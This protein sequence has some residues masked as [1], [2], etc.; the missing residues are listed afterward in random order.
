[1]PDPHNGYRHKNTSD[2]V[3]GVGVRPPKPV[4]TNIL[5]RPLKGPPMVPI[6]DADP[7]CTCADMDGFAD[8]PVHI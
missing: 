3:V 6:K 4:P 5:I 7:R 8:C 2:K 1:M